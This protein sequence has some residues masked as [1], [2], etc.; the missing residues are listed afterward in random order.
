MKQQ[1]DRCR[2]E[3]AEAEAKARRVRPIPLSIANRAAGFRGLVKSVEGDY[4]QKLWRRELEF[5]E[6]REEVLP[7]SW[8]KA[9]HK[10]EA[11]LG[12][13][14]R[15]R[16][17]LEA[18]RQRKAEAFRRAEEAAQS[19]TNRPPPLILIDGTK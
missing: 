8:T 1:G 11:L 19:G 10:F 7:E 12:R 14:L 4:W 15:T 2:R 13:P 16:E 3:C 5:W 9:Q 6:Y 17:Q 18:D